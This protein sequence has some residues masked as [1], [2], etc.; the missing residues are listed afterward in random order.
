LKSISVFQAIRGHLET[1]GPYFF[2]RVSLP[3][4]EKVEILTRDLD[5]LDAE[6]WWGKGNDWVILTHGLEGSSKAAYIRAAAS[7][8]L[9]AG[10]N[11]LAWNFRACSGR[12]N[13]KPR[14][15]H[16]G[17][18]TDLADVVEFVSS[19]FQPESIFPIGFSLGGNLSLVFFAQMPKEWLAE[20]KVKKGMA[21]SVPLN[22]AASSRKLEL[23]HNYPYAFNFLRELK[24][25]ILW[26]SRQFPNI[27][28]KDAINRCHSVWIFDD[29]FTAPIHGFRDAA[30][31][32]RQ[33]SSL[34]KISKI[35]IPVK[36]LLAQNDPMLARGNYPGLEKLNPLVSIDI[37]KNGGHCGFWGQSIF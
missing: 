20:R 22:L 17:A 18:Y 15:Y 30:D 4:S 5:F 11:V 14:L 33:C 36:I 21:I 32:Y 13:L 19:S 16:S 1:L 8:F 34:F 6:I 28:Q 23:W 10:K 31:Y 35:S 37:R 12:L 29:H 25:K 27:F 26:K 24:A 2:R 7:H 9:K 3:E